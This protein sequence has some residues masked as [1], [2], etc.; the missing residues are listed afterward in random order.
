MLTRDEMITSLKN[1]DVVVVFEKVDGTMRKM[2]ATLNE[3]RIP[4]EKEEKE[5][6]RKLS[7]SVVRVFDLDKKEW[8]SFRVDSV[9]FFGNEAFV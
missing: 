5:T 2:V 4:K 9:K 3:D 7:E 6:T 8:R 1:N